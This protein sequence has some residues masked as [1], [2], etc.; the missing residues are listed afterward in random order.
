MKEALGLF[1]SVYNME[2]FKKCHTVLFLNKND[3]FREKIKK[4]S[5]EDYFKDYKGKA[6]H[7]EDGIAFITK[8][9]ADQRANKEKLLYSHVTCAT[10]RDNVQKMF[11]AV[12]DIIVRR[13]L[14][15]A[16]FI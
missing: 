3:L 7:Y 1:R 11:N 13:E 5:L 4:Y 10:N 6:N 12:R 8:K 9:F 14:G 2:A 16:G 15:H